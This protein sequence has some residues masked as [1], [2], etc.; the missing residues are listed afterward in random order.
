LTEK[1]V[2]KKQSTT[3]GIVVSVVGLILIIAGGGY[4]LYK[5]Y[6]LGH[7]SLLHLASNP[8]VDA[9]GVVGLIVLILG[10]ALYYRARSTTKPATATTNQSGEMGTK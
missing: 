4:A 1:E 10:V 3:L 7:S 2:K 6:V 8:I 5:R 9:L